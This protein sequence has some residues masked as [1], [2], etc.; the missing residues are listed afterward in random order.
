[1]Y[2]LHLHCTC[3]ASFYPPLRHN[4]KGPI[5]DCACMVPGAGDEGH[6]VCQGDAAEEVRAGP[7]GGGVFQR[8]PFTL[9]M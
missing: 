8:T 9:M 5:K 2:F 6:G 7:L 1:M 4:G 3:S